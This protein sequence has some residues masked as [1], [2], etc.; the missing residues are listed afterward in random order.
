[1]EKVAG[2]KMGARQTEPIVEVFG[3]IF[4]ETFKRLSEGGKNACTL[5]AVPLHGRCHHDL[6]QN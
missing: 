4:E 5:G 6:H 2:G 1:M 3:T